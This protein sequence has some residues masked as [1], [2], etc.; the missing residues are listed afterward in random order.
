MSFYRITS[1][2]GVEMGIY[3]GGTQAEALDAMARACGYLSE[4]DATE[5]VGEAFEGTIVEVAGRFVVETRAPRLDSLGERLLWEPWTSAEIG[6][7]P[8][9]SEEECERGI[10]SLKAHGGEWLEC[11]YRI[12]EVDS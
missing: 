4:A 2:Q 10:A 6:D 3:E 1:S 11:E 7:N 5:V 9:R 12:L 8:P